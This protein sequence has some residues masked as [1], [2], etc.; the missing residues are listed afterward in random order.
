MGR[1]LGY[2]GYRRRARGFTLIELLLVVSVIAVLAALLLPAVNR[3]REGAQERQAQIEARIIGQ[4]ISAYKLRERRFPTTHLDAGEDLRYGDGDNDDHPNSVVMGILREADP[5]VLDEDSLRW[6]GDNVLN[7]WGRQ[8]RITL[9]LDYD[10]RI[11][12]EYRDYRV[13]WDIRDDEDS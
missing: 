5:P 13:Q 8:Y 3:V 11:D 1:D 2:V 10:G 12:G 4:A 6:D 9:D 7:P